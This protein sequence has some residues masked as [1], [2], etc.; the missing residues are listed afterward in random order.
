M[1]FVVKSFWFLESLENHSSTLAA[2]STSTLKMP[3]RSRVGAVA[4][5]A[6][7]VTKNAMMN[8]NLFSASQQSRELPR[9]ALD[10]SSSESESE[11][12][13]STPTPQNKERPKS[14]DKDEESRA[15]MSYA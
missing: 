13:F 9:L 12:S 11:T 7:P 2:G 4:S 6:L 1:L 15:G 8:R 14:A 10:D 3:K 5:L